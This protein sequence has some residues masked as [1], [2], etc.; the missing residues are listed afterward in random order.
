MQAFL[1]MSVKLLSSTLPP[2]MQVVGRY[3]IGDANHKGAMPK[4]RG[5]MK[6][7]VMKMLRNGTVLAISCLLAYTPLMI[8]PPSAAAGIDDSVFFYRA[9][10]CMRF[11]SYLPRYW[12]SQAAERAYQS[13]NK[14]YRIGVNGR[15]FNV[16]T[17][18]WF[19]SAACE[20][21]GAAAGVTAT[22]SLAVFGNA[23]VV[24]AATG[25]AP[26]LGALAAVYVTS[27]VAGYLVL[28]AYNNTFNC[29]Y[30]VVP[31]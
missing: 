25:N 23:A 31:A 12:A 7:F 9:S 16:D 21:I 30:E 27:A 24:A 15:C 4:G 13:G 10:N 1:D 20:G 29:Q 19:A 5:K 18:G 2:L 17:L 11:D 22:Y 28:R 3:L 6:R 8:A 14:S 26:V